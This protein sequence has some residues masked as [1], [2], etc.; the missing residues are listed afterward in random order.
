L[1]FS[2]FKFLDVLMMVVVVVETVV[3]AVAVAVG[4]VEEVQ[5]VGQ[6]VLQSS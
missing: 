6:L 3:V 5:T 1:L 2:D 4:E